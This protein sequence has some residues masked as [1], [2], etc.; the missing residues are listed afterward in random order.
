VHYSPAHDSRPIATLPAYPYNAADDVRRPGFNGRLFV[1]RPVIGGV[2]T[3][4]TAYPPPGPEYYGAHGEECQT[5]PVR[6][7]HLVIGVSPWVAWNRPGHQ[8]IEHARQLWLRESG[9]TGGVRTFV[10][11]LHFVR[12]EPVVSGEPRTMPEPAAIIELSPDAPRHRT[13]LRV[14]IDGPARVS[15]PHNAPI[16]AVARTDASGGYLD[17][18]VQPSPVITAAK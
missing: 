2:H 16:A 9:Y 5:V 17:F 11:D 8:H 6:V 15:W 4:H 10:N 3:G 18:G 1:T 12:E 14:Q 7:G 13:R